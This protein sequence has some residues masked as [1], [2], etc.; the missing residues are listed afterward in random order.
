MRERKSDYVAWASFSAGTMRTSVYP[1][2]ELGRRQKVK[3][4]GEPKGGEGSFQAG[5]T[6]YRLYRLVGML[7]LPKAGD[8][9][10]EKKTKKQKD[11]GTRVRDQLRGG[12]TVAGYRGRGRGGSFVVRYRS[13]KMQTVTV[14]ALPSHWPGG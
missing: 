7:T 9:K 10:R 14:F 3:G 5:P 12:R 2:D 11:N 4:G 8:E 1:K 13:Y 6:S